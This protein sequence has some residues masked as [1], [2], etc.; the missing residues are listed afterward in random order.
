MH[1]ID[2]A[3][4]AHYNLEFAQKGTKNIQAE[5]RMG[6]WLVETDQRKT[7]AEQKSISESPICR[8]LQHKTMSGSTDALGY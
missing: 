7:T 3:D 2:H 4:W 8:A 1:K 5:L 6:K